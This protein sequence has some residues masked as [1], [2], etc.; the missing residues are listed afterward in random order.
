[1]HMLI[2]STTVAAKQQCPFQG[3]PEE[4]Q[5]DCQQPQGRQ[6]MY[7]CTSSLVITCTLIQVPS[8]HVRY[9][10]QL[11]PSVQQVPVGPV[12]AVQTAVMCMNCDEP[13][14]AL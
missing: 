3:D 1:M 9:A 6:E 5:K 4:L 14:D 11:H 2:Y 13:A 10:K 8:V 7:V 12:L